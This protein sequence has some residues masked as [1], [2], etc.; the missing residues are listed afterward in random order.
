MGVVPKKSQLFTR[1][2]SL[3]SFTGDSAYRILYRSFIYLHS[4]KVI[5]RIHDA[6]V[7]FNFFDF[8]GCSLLQIST[9]TY[10]HNAVIVPVA[11]NTSKK[12]KSSL[13]V[14]G[15]GV[16]N[17]ARMRGTVAPPHGGMETCDAPI[18]LSV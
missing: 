6:S 11:Y 9:A 16:C 7:L 18:L 3:L 2:H 17:L 8:S 10:R 5:I 13:A 15:F 14:T 12:T 1:V 4:G